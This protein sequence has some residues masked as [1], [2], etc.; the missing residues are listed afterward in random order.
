[1]LSEVDA[2]RLLLIE[3]QG[4]KVDLFASFRPPETFAASASSDR[5]FLQGRSD[6]P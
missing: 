5:G 1:M 4:Y 3:T 2:N 6:L